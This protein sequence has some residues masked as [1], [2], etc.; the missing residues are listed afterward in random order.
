MQLRPSGIWPV[1]RVSIIAG[2]SATTWLVRLPPPGSGAAPSAVCRYATDGLRVLR[3]QSTLIDDES[4]QDVTVSTR[5][6]WHP[7]E[8][9]QGAVFQWT[10]H[11]TATATFRAEAS[12]P[13]I[14]ILDAVGA[15]PGTGPQPVTIRINGVVV[16]AAWQG[17]GRLEIPAGV[18]R[19]GDNELALEVSQVVVPPRDW[20]PLGVLV[21]GLRLIDPGAR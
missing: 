21:R 20:R 4:A 17:A 7:A 10:G 6:G 2:A 5:D 12:G 3:G 19:P 1:P 11:R 14:L 8:R 13:R 9:A 18:L 15:D 16:H